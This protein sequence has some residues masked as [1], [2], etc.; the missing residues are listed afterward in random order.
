MKGK[1]K[2]LKFTILA[3]LLVAFFVFL[4][5][6]QLHGDTTYAIV[7]GRSME[8]TI[9]LGSLVI[10]KPA[11]EYRE[12]DIVAFRTQYSDTVV[13]HRIVGVRSSPEGVSFVTKGDASP[14]PDGWT[15]TPQMVLGK[16]RVAI[17]YLGFTAAFLHSPLGLALVVTAAF[18][19]VFSPSEVVGLLRNPARG[20]RRARRTAQP[21]ASLRQ[22]AETGGSS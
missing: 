10:A 4:R 9:H 11:G 15:V 8:P 20:S 2:K 22:N 5:P 6:T 18:F 3:I 16:V 17:P 1:L 7:M 12:G 19:L 21:H 14:N 13:V